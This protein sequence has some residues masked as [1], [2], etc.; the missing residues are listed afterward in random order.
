MSAS[1]FVLNSFPIHG[2]SHVYQPLSIM[3]DRVLP[4]LDFVLVLH[5]C[6][7]RIWVM[8]R[9]GPGGKGTGSGPQPV[10]RRQL[11]VDRLAA[12][13]QAPLLIQACRLAQQLLVNA[14]ALKMV[15]DEPSRLLKETT[16]DIKFIFILK[17]V[18]YLGLKS[19]IFWW[20][21]S[22]ARSARLALSQELY[23]SSNL[24]PGCNQG[25]NLLY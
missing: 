8:S 20:K 25:S 11:T 18:A 12:A 2:Y 22:S 1:V 10:P 19:S 16:D 14:F 4:E 7:F 21:Y 15:S 5:P 3:E 6:S 13:S 17:T 23:A 9:S 24:L